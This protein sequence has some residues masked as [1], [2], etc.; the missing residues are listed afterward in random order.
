MATPQQ[1]DENRS[2]L[3]NITMLALTISVWETLGKTSLAFSAPIGN[4]ILTWFQQELGLELSFEDP[5]SA[6]TKVCQI[7]ID[8]FSIASDIEISSE[9]QGHYEVRISN[10]QNL[11][12]L[13]S[14]AANGIENLFLDPVLNTCQAVLRQCDL[15]M[16]QDLQL[17][18]EGQG[19]ILT[20][21]A[22]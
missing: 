7:L 3:N 18:D 15:R 17:W 13:R 8:V 11:S 1:Q 6:L 10:Y 22:V 2:H 19:I 20:F 4:Y 14:M 12:F 5:R 9:H 21:T 16:Y